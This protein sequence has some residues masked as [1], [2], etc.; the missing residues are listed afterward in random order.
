MTDG[1]TSVELEFHFGADG[2]IAGIYSPSR[3]GSFD[4]GFRQ[5]RWQGHFAD[6]I[7]VQGVK[8]PSRGEVGWYDGEQWECVWQ[9]RILNATVEMAQSQGR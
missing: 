3:W 6:Y 2:M 1:E 4:G 7:E 8:V 9:G 5:E